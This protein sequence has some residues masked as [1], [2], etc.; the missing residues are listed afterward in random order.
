MTIRAIVVN[1]LYVGD[2]VWKRRTDGRF[3]MIRGGHAVDRR[4]VYGARLVPNGETDCLTI[5]DTHE[6]I[7]AR[8][9]FDQAGQKRLAHVRSQH[10]PDHGKTWNGQRSQFILSGLM[11]R[12]LCGSRYQGVTRTS[13]RRGSDGTARKHR[14]YGC[15][16]YI[17]RGT[18]VCTK[19]HAIPQKLL[20]SVVI[21]VVLDFYQRH[22]DNF[23][24]KR[25]AAAVQDQVG[26][27]AKEMVAAHERAQREH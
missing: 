12:E 2:M 3:H 9:L 4:A 24:R 26:C 8:R 19:L 17:T 18:S 10:N 20:E 7:I 22:Q 21:K 6:A 1:P 14:Y 23:G 11:Q 5:R 16:G 13:G 27:E 25:L 15:G